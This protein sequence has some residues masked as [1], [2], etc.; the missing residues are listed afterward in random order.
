V[1]PRTGLE[2]PVGYP[3]EMYSFL[4]SPYHITWSPISYPRFEHPYNIC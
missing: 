1:G 3:T 2:V 4:M